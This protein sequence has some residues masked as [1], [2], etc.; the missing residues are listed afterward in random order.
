[1]PTNSFPTNSLP[2]GAPERIV[3]QRPSDPRT[4]AFKGLGNPDGPG[5]G[6]KERRAMSPPGPPALATNGSEGKGDLGRGQ[7]PIV[8]GPQEGDGMLVNLPKGSLVL[9]PLVVEVAQPNGSMPGD[10]VGEVMGIVASA[11]RHRHRMAILGAI[12]VVGLVL[13]FLTTHP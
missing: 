8:E 13:G 3:V 7:S 4:V 6:M 12:A 11:L 5:K 1:M 9:R 2:V 10:T